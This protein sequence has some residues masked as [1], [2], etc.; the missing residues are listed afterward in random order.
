MEHEEWS[1]VP[2]EWKQRVFFSFIK[3]AIKDLRRLFPARGRQERNLE[4][5]LEMLSFRDFYLEIFHP[6]FQWVQG[7]DKA[8]NHHGNSVNSQI[9][10][11]PRD[12]TAGWRAFHFLSE[13]VDDF[14]NIRPPNVFLTLQRS[15][16]L[17][18]FLTFLQC[19][20]SWKSFPCCI[21]LCLYRNTKITGSIT[22]R[23]RQNS[24]FIFHGS[25]VPLWSLDLFIQSSRPVWNYSKMVSPL[26]SFRNRPG[27]SLTSSS[28]SL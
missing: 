27:Q 28:S 6:K 5:N 16:C 10:T 13:T 23:T 19:K 17:F 14:W 22:N 7:N 11:V 26:T 4:I 20:V 3:K 24:P 15:G 9:P 18:V 21:L 25:P 8:V 1:Y 2:P 12:M